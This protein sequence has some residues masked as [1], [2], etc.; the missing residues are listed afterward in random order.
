MKIKFEVLGPNLL[1][2]Q[3]LVWQYFLKKIVFAF[4]GKLIC[5]FLVFVVSACGY[6]IN[7]VMIFFFYILKLFV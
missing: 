4:I 7:G 5:N 2:L 3:D 1:C 6:G